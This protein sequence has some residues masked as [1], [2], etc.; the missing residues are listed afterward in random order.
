MIW[1]ADIELPSAKSCV[2]VYPGLN[3]K[4][5]GKAPHPIASPE[6]A[7]WYFG[8]TGYDELTS[9]LLCKDC[10]DVLQLSVKLN[11][12]EEE[13]E[14]SGVGMEQPDKNHFWSMDVR[15]WDPKGAGQ[16]LELCF[17]GTNQFLSL[18]KEHPR[19]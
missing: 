3:L 12:S 18:N 8:K 16:V 11:N 14:L 19:V 4:N 13:S 2:G 6:A 5:K 10:R 15:R 17:Q 7:D 1:P 9:I